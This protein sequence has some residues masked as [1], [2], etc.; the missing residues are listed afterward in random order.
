MTD[1]IN[2]RVLKSTWKTIKDKR[3]KAK[4]P[5][6]KLSLTDFFDVMVNHREQLD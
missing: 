1:T 2:M 6:N 4:Y 3:K 5:L